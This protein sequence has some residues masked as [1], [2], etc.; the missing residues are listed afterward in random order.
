MKK[1]LV[2]LLVLGMAAPAMAAEWNWWGNARVLASWSTYSD[3]EKLAGDIS[4]NGNAGVIS[5]PEGGYVHMIGANVKA[6]DT[7]EAAF[8]IGET[9]N[10]AAAFRN[11]FATWNF[12]PGRMKVG[13]MEMPITTIWYGPIQVGDNPLLGP[14]PYESRHD[15]IQ[16][17]FGGFELAFAKNAS[18]V[19]D[20]AG[21]NQ[22]RLIPKIEAAYTLNVGAMR[23]RFGI[24]YQTYDLVDIA[25]EESDSVD[26][27]VAIMG[28]RYNP[29][30]WQVG[31]TGWYAQNPNTHRY[32]AAGSYVGYEIVNG[33]V[34]DGNAWGASLTGR[35]NIND[36]VSLAAGGGYMAS[37]RDVGSNDY[38][39][40]QL[41][42]FFNVN[43]NLAPGV[44][45]TPEIGA[46][47]YGENELNGAALDDRG[48][49]YYF[50]TR[51]M[52]IF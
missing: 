51:F 31:M 45:I 8:Q 36:L 46:Y 25:T 38:E 3:E 21:Y 10:E 34:E 35:F 42:A 16:F 48:E 40:D 28:V 7:L 49:M 52:I 12:G 50:S 18:G 32:V 15:S 41:N 47:W 9:S 27:Y 5:I 2:V 24:S 6:S 44:S 4:T 20:P 23:A 17:Q 11:L 22:E 19:A 29:G 13:H 39:D 14:Q 26:S 33:E 1:L 30:P 37:M 43:F